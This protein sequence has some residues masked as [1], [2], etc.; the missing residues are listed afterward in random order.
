MRPR[1]GLDGCGK[2]RPYRDSILGPSSSYE[3]VIPATLSRPL[4]CN[5]L[6]LEMIH[7][8]ERYAVAQPMG[9]LGYKPEGHVFDF[10]W[11]FLRHF[12]D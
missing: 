1:I 2:P 10:R 3:V 9:A 12:I 4:F 11:G 7:L 5:S 6:E 8:Y